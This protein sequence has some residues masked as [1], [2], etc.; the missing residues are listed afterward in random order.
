[1]VTA[2]VIAPEA[3]K[4][5]LL[6]GSRN[7]FQVSVNVTIGQPVTSFPGTGSGVAPQPDQAQVEVDLKK[8]ENVIAVRLRTNGKGEAIYMRFHDPD[9]KLRYPE[10]AQDKK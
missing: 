5:K 7:N 4:V 3:M 1:V 9:R 10:P 6:V 2:R 8:G